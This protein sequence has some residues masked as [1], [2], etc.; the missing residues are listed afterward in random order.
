MKPLIALFLCSQPALELSLL[1]P[2]PALH[3]STLF[4][5]L[6]RYISGF[7]GSF[8]YL[9]PSIAAITSSPQA[10]RDLI[11]RTQ[12]DQLEVCPKLNPGDNF[13]MSCS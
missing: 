5:F 7:E 10:T 13:A 4:F 9:Q 8:R 2:C 12:L 3:P 6:D 11:E 1:T